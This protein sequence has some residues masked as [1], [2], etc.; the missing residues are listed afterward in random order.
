MMNQNKNRCSVLLITLTISI[1][2]VGCGGGEEEV[3]KPVVTQKPAPKKPKAKT[4]EELVTK[5][6]IDDRIFLS[7]NEAPRLETERVALLKFFDAMAQVD[8]DALKSMLS[9][10]D[11]VELDTM[12]DEDLESFM[13]NVSL[14]E[15]FTGDSPEG[16]SC[17][18]AFYEIDMEYQVQMWYY[19]GMG[20]DITFSAAETA[21]NLIDKISGN[22]VQNYFELESKLDEI[23]LHP[24]EET[25]YTLAGEL[26]SSDGA[27]GTD[28]SRPKSPPSRPGGPIERPH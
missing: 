22:L 2:G 8:L 15:L 4:V 17:V 18:M 27:V 7:E 5:L 1:F 14:I 24:D 28:E 3:K 6:G 11:H 23:A 10:N 21:P 20:S 9:Y 19:D 25:S 13:S 12:V 26:T 16:R